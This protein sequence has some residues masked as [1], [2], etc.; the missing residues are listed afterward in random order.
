LVSI[1]PVHLRHQ[2][3]AVITFQ[4]AFKG[5]VLFAHFA[6]TGGDIFQLVDIQPVS[7][8]AGKCRHQRFGGR[9]AVG[10]AH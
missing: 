8:A 3:A 5:V 1:R 9:V 10:G 7:S 2:N 4:L 6:E